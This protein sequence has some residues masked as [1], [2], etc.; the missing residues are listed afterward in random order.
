M[1]LWLQNLPHV[2]IAILEGTALGGGLELALACD[3]LVAAWFLLQ[4]LCYFLIF[5]LACHRGRTGKNVELRASR[6]FEGVDSLSVRLLAFS[7][8]SSL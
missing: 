8:T 4:I 3:L 5:S 7:L 2:T 1:R 6:A